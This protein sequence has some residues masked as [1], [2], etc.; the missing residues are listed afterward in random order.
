M[1]MPQSG[2]GTSGSSEDDVAL[3]GDDDFIGCERGDAAGV[4]E[5][6]DGNEGARGKAWKDMGMGTTG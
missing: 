4:A 3:V 6:S 2:L 1:E 5:D